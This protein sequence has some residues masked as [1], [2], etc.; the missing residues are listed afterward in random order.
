MNNE[1]G[2]LTEDVF[3]QSVKA[4]AWLL[5]A[6]YNKMKEEIDILKNS[7]LD[8]LEVSYLSRL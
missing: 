4:T 1:L 3:K 6:A 2:C 8:D 5:L 7:T